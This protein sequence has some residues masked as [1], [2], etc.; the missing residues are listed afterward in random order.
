[1]QEITNLEATAE[2]KIRYTDHWQ[3]GRDGCKL[4]A[5]ALQKSSLELNDFYMTEF[6]ALNLYRPELVRKILS[7]VL[8]TLSYKS[9]TI[10]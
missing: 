10:K 5:P 1:V 8:K 3:M 7:D 4:F 2:V 6:L 9:S